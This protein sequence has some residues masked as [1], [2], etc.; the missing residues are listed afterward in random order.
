MTNPSGV[1]EALLREIPELRPTHDDH[2]AD[3]AE[4]AEDEDPTLLTHLLFDEFADFTVEAYEEG[5]T[6]VVGRVLLSMERLLAEDDDLTTELVAE[7]FVGS[8]S[9]ERVE[10]RFFDLYGMLMRAEFESQWGKPWWR[11]VTDDM[12][13]FLW[14]NSIPPQAVLLGSFVGDELL[15]LLLEATAPS[16]PKGRYFRRRTRW[17]VIRLANNQGGWS[18]RVTRYRGRQLSQAQQDFVFA[19]TVADRAMLAT[20]RES[21]ITEKA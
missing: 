16:R 18:S 19:A 13:L 12:D 10:A 8:I 14:A 2:V 7:S 20:G 5:R 9:P 4:Q 21:V 6:E 15:G 1:V 17:L 11:K 3:H